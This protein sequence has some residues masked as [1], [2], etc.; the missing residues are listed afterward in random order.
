MSSLAN[1]GHGV[2]LPRDS[3]WDGR[4]QDKEQ[5]AHGRD[6]CH[7]PG[8]PHRHKRVWMSQ[9]VGL[10]RTAVMG[11]AGNRA[12]GGATTPD[13]TLASVPVA[14]AVQEGTS[15][16]TV[17]SRPSGRPGS[18]NSDMSAVAPSGPAPGTLRSSPA[19]NCRIARL[20]RPLNCPPAWRHT[21]TGVPRCPTTLLP[22]RSLLGMAR[23][24]CAR[25]VRV[26]RTAAR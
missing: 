8:L 1:R 15:T 5:L 6:E 16:S 22:V 19:W 17:I 23:S 14:A 2:L 12:D 4:V 20:R 3:V 21:A 10:W 18:G 7:L 13:A 11:H 26:P 25:W 24:E 9:R